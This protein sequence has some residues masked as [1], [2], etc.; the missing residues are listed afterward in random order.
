MPKT[1]SFPVTFKFESQPKKERKKNGMCQKLRKERLT[2]H[3]NRDPTCIGVHT[4]LNKNTNKQKCNIP[5][6][7]SNP[8]GCVFIRIGPTMMNSSSYFTSQCPVNWPKVNNL[9]CPILRP[10]LCVISKEWVITSPSPSRV[11]ISHYWPE[12]QTK[13]TK[14]I[15]LCFRW[16][17]KNY[18]S[19]SSSICFYKLLDFMI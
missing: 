8:V 19:L 16:H 1:T 13:G 12:I 9:N 3:N 11:A 7:A 18:Y 14:T 15:I 2:A 4:Q 10:L 6:D 17:N 5:K